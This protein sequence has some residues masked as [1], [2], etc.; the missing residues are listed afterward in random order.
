MLKLFYKLSYLFNEEGDI[1]PNSISAL[2]V[3]HDD[4]MDMIDK[5][6]RGDELK[7]E[8]A[9]LTGITNE[10][11]TIINKYCGAPIA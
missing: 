6:C 9:K 5:Y 11:I 8:T 7:M 4:V 10:L 2:P 3:D 1:N